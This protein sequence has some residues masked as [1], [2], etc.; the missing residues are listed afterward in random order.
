MNIR[1]LTRSA[2][3]VVIA[4]VA[5]LSIFVQAASAGEI[6]DPTVFRDRVA[7][8]GSTGPDFDA[9]AKFSIGG[10]AYTGT[11]DQ[12]N[13]AAAVGWTATGNIAVGNLTNA[14][15]SLGASIGGNIPVGSLTNAAG[16]LGASIGGNIPVASLTNGA[17]SLGGSI[18]GNIPV[19]SLTNAAGS[20]GASIGGNIPVAAVTN[21]AR[22]IGASIGGNIP[23][24]AM[25]NA[26]KWAVTNIWG[27]AV[28]SGTI[29]NFDGT[30]I[31]SVLVF[32]D[33]ML[34]TKTDL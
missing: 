33:G 27:A 34:T 13:Q 30:A 5:I 4:I 2:V 15:G 26:I 28:Y 24:A 20:I 6:R 1:R 19:A 17:G 32:V 12:L 31:T 7:F 3:F 14:A 22:T 16:S 18:G 25:T 8:R 29:T 10:T 9:T 23:A 11:V 21:A